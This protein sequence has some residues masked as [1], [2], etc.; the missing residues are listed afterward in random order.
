MRLSDE[1]SF[2]FT[3]GCFTGLHLRLFKLAFT[4]IYFVIQKG[5]PAKPVL[6]ERF[7]YMY[8]GSRL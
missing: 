2:C 5:G 7:I 4:F 3:E 6:I 8:R 1:F